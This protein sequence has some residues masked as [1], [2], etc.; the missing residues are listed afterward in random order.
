MMR[1]EGRELERPRG[2]VLGPLGLLLAA[3]MSAFGLWHALTTDPDTASDERL[4]HLGRHPG[5]YRAR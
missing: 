4:S 3:A 2:A 5:Q 1:M